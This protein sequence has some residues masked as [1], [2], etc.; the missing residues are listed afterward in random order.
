M[1]KNIFV[2]RHPKRFVV[3]VVGV[4]SLGVS[5]CGSA[6]DMAEVSASNASQSSDDSQASGAGVQVDP[7]TASA[8]AD[9]QGT[10]RA[11]ELQYGDS[12]VDLLPAIDEA[13]E[14]R[15][16]SL[17]GFQPIEWDDLVPS[18]FSSEQ[19]LARYEDRL[20]AVEPGS[21]EIDELYAEMNAEYDAASLNTELDSE[22]VQLAGFVAPLTYVGDEITEFLLVPYFGACI[23]VPPPPANQTVMVSLAEGESLSLEESWGAVWV[24]GEMAAS[25]VDTALATAGY[26]ISGP[27]FGVYNS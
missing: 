4:L 7:T 2:L 9:H 13:A 14:Q 23:H 19:I 27:A 26:T 18:G 6:N 12:I 5:A 11:G 25:S 15:I 17:P 22:K 10:G 24:A 21:A 1:T 16:T 20:E 8:S 3:G